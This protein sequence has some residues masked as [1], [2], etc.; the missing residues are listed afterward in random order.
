MNFKPTAVWLALTASMA[1]AIAVP[2][3]LSGTHFDVTYDSS[4]VGLFG[5][6]NLTGDVLTWHPSGS[7]GFTAQ[8]TGAGIATTNSTF[9]LGITAKS[10]FTLS[11]FGLAEAGDYFYFTGPL[12]NSFAGVSVTGQLRLT[13]PPSIGTTSA[14][15]VSSTVFAANP[16]FDFATHNWSASAGPL[17]AAAGTTVANVSVQNILNAYASDALSKAYIEKKDVFLTVHVSQ[18]PEPETFAM[19]LAGLGAIGFLASRRNK[20]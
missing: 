12:A 18:V 4:L 3:T 19:F 9:A 6:P 20:D 5:A 11:S 10:G 16:A 7:P 8:T 1:S 15:I 17:T 13:L 14:P 2:V